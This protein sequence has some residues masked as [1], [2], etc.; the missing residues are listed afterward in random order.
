MNLAILCSAY[1]ANTT[2]SNSIQSVIDQ[3]YINWELFIVNDGS[4]DNTLDKIY[5]ISKSDSRIKVYDQPN[6]GLTASLHNM[7][8]GSAKKYEWIARIDADDIWHKDKLMLQVNAIA[9]NPELV[10]IGTN[11]IVKTKKGSAKINYPCDNSSIQKVL[12]TRNCFAHSSVL[13]RRIFSN[14]TLNY[15][16]KWHYSQDY[17]LWLRLRKFGKFCNLSEY[18]V[19][20]M[21]YSDAITIKNRYF[22]KIFSYMARDSHFKLSKLE[23]ILAF[24]ELTV[25]VAIKK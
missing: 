14:A 25:G 11:C 1:N 19:D 4:T 13:F 20:R 18:L 2:I 15:D 5:E 8:C 22:Q 6:M 9:E 17:E 12:R 3:N 16:I 24:A 23:K 10:L 21:L 7:L